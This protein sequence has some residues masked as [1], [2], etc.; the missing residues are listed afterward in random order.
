MSKYTKELLQDLVEK[1]ISV[2]EIIKKLGLKQA[3]GTHTHI[4]LKIKE[5]KINTSHFLGQS[6]NKIHKSSKLKK[7]FSEILVLRDNSNKRQFAVYLRRALIESGRE[8]KCEL[9]SLT[10]QWNNKELRLEVD[11][12]NNNWLD[13]RAE[14]LRFICPNCHSQ[15]KHKGNKGQTGLIK[16]NFQ[17][18]KKPSFNICLDCFK[19]ISAG[20]KRCKSCKGKQNKNK[21]I[22]PNVDELKSMLLNDSYCEIARRLGVSDNA[23]RKRIKNHQILYQTKLS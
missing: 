5:F 6:A 17:I 19:Q 10:D 18:N 8:Y 15:Q 1:S 9:C 12:K 4:S 2:A 21:I 16:I 7:H 22:W 14:N 11:H 20:A 13:D 3:G 23:I